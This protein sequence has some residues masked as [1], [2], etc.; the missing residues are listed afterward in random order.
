MERCRAERHGVQ[1]SVG[2]SSYA[3]TDVSCMYFYGG[4]WI[5]AMVDFHSSLTSLVSLPEETP[6]LLSARGPAVGNLDGSH[7]DR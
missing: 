4:V 3:E 5:S 2:R 1:G 7:R 6:Y